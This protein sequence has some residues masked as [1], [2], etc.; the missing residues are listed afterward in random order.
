MDRRANI[1]RLAP[2]DN[3]GVAL[4]DIAAGEMA[5][6]RADFAV[7][8]REHI[9]LGHKIAL[10]AD[11]R[12]TADRPVRHGGRGW[13]GRPLPRACWC[14]STM[15]AA[16]ISTTRS[17]IMS[18]GQARPLAAI[19]RLDLSRMRGY[20]RQDGR[21]GIRN[22]LVG[23]LSRRVRPS[24]RAP[25][26]RAVPGAGRAADRLPRLLPERL[27]APHSRG[28]VHPPQC[29]CRAAGVARLRGIPARRP[30]GGN[31]AVGAPGRADGHPGAR[32][33]AG[34]DR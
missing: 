29:R 25:H 32:R 6:D 27:C 31:R 18:D 21:K 5:V 7:A 24:C 23:R 12:R 17:T 3:V 13:R 10:A 28:H 4:S 15:S 26:C 2:A 33:D 34:N 22:Y 19:P 30:Q 20:P 8:A 1:V 16:S 14:T 9:P 11:R